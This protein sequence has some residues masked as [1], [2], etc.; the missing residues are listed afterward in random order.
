MSENDDLRETLRRVIG[1]DVMRVSAGGAEDHL[2]LIAVASAFAAMLFLEFIK[3]AAEELKRKLVALA[4][5]KGVATADALW[6]LVLRAVGI[7][8]ISKPGTA[9]DEEFKEARGLLGEI[10]ATIKA[11]PD[12]FDLF[13]SAGQQAV[14]RQLVV[15]NFPTELA[16]KKAVAF[17]N[18]I[19]GFVDQLPPSGK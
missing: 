3:S 16:K 11:Q 7:T 15:N 9:Q 2:D 6:A 10:S 12:A 13:L 8:P 4:H 1:V 19:Q 14:E 18:A 5:D 17:R